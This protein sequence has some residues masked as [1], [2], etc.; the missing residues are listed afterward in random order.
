MSGLAGWCGE[1]VEGALDAMDAAAPWRGPAVTRHRAARFEVIY[2]HHARPGQAPRVLVGATGAVTAVAGNLAPSSPDPA[3][4]LDRRLAASDLG[5]LDGAFAAARYA[6]GALTLAVDPFGVGPL[7]WTEAAGTLYFASDLGQIAALPH[8]GRDVDPAAIHAYL[9]FSF[10]PGANTL[11]RGVRRVLPGHLLRWRGP[12]TA[13]AV[14]WFQL[15]ERVDPAFADPTAAVRAVRATAK[16]AIRRR[17]VG[18]RPVAVFLSGG[19]DSSAVTAWL[20]LVGRDVTALSLDFGD[21][22]VEREQAAQVARALEVPHLWVPA[23]GARVG[24]VLD[25]LDRAMD[26]PF[27]DPV[28]G[29]QWLLAD[30]ARTAG[31]E[32]V[33]NGEGG[34]QLFGGWTS[35][36]MVAAAV[37]AGL[38]DD[39]TPEEEYLRA[40]HRFYGLEDKLYT[41]SLAARVGAPGARRAMLRAYL[42]DES[43]SFYLNRVRLADLSL[44]GQF[45]IVPR[46][47]RIAA[48][49]GLSLRMPLFDRRLAELAFQLPPEL[50]LHGACEKY[51]FKLALQGRLPDDVVWRRKF[52]MSVPV[53]DWLL[54][55]ASGGPGALTER[56]NDELSEA[57]V[58]RRGWFQP[59]FVAQLRAGL[60]VANETRRRRVGEKLWALWTL[61]RWARRFLGAP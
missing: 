11:L 4:E 23:D 6:D 36:P 22:S 39:L 40:Y 47:E 7:Y 10:V 30:A 38:Y 50:K 27:G 35:K 26:L 55:P 21:A 52:G 2:R 16:D 3:A 59:G 57:S 42:G 33:F 24:G 29:P 13:E 1:R 61:E 60:D 44:K 41:P 8:V 5:D 14:P 31:F 20:K 9:T 34:D 32:V 46:A 17:L 37:Y 28:T 48:A 51:V 25:A 18:E 58:R 45:N 54:G 19:V 15:H 43:T 12:G 56:M 53:T 49:H